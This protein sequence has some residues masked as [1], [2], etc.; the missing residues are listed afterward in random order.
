MFSTILGSAGAGRLRSGC[1]EHERVID[2]QMD[3]ERPFNGRH[4]DREGLSSVCVGMRV[5][6]SAFEFVLK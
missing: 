4:F 2:K 3:I 1:D 6:R 5:T